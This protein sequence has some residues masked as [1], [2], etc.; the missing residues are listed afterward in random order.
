MSDL[1]FMVEGNT[2]G[3]VKGRAEVMGHDQ[4]GGV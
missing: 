1:A 2:I 4:A 3:N